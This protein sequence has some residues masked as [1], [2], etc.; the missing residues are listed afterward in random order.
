MYKNDIFLFQVI[1]VMSSFM[2]PTESRNGT[3]MSRVRF[4]GPNQLQKSTA[5]R[6]WDRVKIVCSQPFSK[7]RV[8][9]YP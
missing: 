9:S 5:Q 3:N 6:K 8:S 1:L 2:S 4:F 7:V